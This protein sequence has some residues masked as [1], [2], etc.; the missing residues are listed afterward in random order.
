M[1]SSVV[2][3]VIGAILTGTGGLFIVV[4]E[5]R[6][7]DRRARGILAEID[8]DLYRVTEAYIDQRRYGFD[9]RRRLTDLGEDTDPMPTIADPDEQR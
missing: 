6:R 5:L 2:L 4:S 7:R 9:L 8:S 3:T 1:N